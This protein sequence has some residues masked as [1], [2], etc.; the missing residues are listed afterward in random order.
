MPEPQ[1]IKPQPWQERVLQ[2]SADIAI[3]GGAAYAGKTYALLLEPLYHVGNPQ[4]GAVCFR[5]TYNRITQEGGLW[6]ET[7]TLYRPIGG[8]PNK[9]ELYWTFPPTG[10]AVSFAHMQYEDDKYAY[11]GAQ[12]ALLLFG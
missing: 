1:V 9:G 3:M 7:Q 10:A 6:D 4:F 2:C 12:I 5:R 8:I 11:H